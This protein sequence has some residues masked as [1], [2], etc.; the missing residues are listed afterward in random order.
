[1]TVAT[2][3]PFTNHHGFEERIEG[4]A[5]NQ[6]NVVFVSICELNSNGV[7]FQGLASMEVHNVVPHREGFLIVRGHIGWDSDLRAQLSIFA[8]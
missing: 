3:H 4:L 6:H 5:I 1:M 2:T 7:P 8:P